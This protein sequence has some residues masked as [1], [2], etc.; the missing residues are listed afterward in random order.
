MLLIYSMTYRFK[1]G[2]V[3]TIISARHK[4]RPSHQAGAHVA[5]NVPIQ[6]RHHHHVKLL[7]FGHKLEMQ[8]KSQ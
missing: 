6:I 7:G 3:P 5:D 4:A 2:I 1:H 8:R